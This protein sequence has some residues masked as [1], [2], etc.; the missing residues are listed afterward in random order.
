LKVTTANGTCADFASA[1]VGAAHRAPR[2]A[3]VDGAQRPV[4]VHRAATATLRDVTS[5]AVGTNH[6]AAPLTVADS[7]I[8]AFS[9]A[10]R[11]ATA[12]WTGRRAI[13]T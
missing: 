7:A 12:S 1:A 5:R 4:A 10:R 9:R 13:R 11:G 8:R 6:P 3:L 2:T